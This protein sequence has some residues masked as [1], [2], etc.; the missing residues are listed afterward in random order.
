[1]N[2]SQ[3]LL[4]AWLPSGHTICSPAV[5]G[6]KIKIVTFFALSVT[7]I[8][9]GGRGGIRTHG[10]FPHARFRVECLKPDSA[11][12]PEKQRNAER[13]TSNAE[14]QLCS[15]S[16]TQTI[17]SNEHVGLVSRACALLDGTNSI[18]FCLNLIECR[19]ASN[20]QSNHKLSVFVQL[21]GCMPR[22]QRHFAGFTFFYEHIFPVFCCSVFVGAR[23]ILDS[24]GSGTKPV[25]HGD[26]VR[27]WT[28]RD[29]AAAFSDD[30]RRTDRL[31]LCRAVVRG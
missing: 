4:I 21:V 12:L 29:A 28:K 9:D 26:S 17:L 2:T 10:G 24:L 30:Q 8:M 5:A 16:V 25:R 22:V 27:W 20:V 13:P 19:G 31:L 11:T 15:T 7:Q 6:G 14:W 3:Q 18:L 1:V 23:W